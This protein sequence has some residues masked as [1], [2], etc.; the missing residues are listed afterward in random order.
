MARILDSIDSPDKLKLL[1]DEE[2][3]ILASEIRQEILRVTSKNG[4]HLASNLGTVEITL[5][6]HSLIDSPHDR[7]LFDVGHQ[8]YTH[9]LVTG[10][11]AEFDTL[12]Q[13]KGL[14][15]FPKPH[16]SA[17]D[18][19]PSGHASD[20]LS[21]AC[22]LARARDLRGE[23]QNIVALIGDAS[24][25]GG[26]AFEAL[27]DIGQAQTPLVIILNDNEMSISRNVGAMAMHLG[28]LRVTNNYRKGRD[29]MQDFMENSLGVAGKAMVKFGKT[30]KESLKQFVLPDTML[31]EQLGIVCTPPVDGHNIT[32]L[33]R[34]IGHALE[35]EVPVLVHVVTKKGAG[36]EPA[37]K[38]PASFHGVGPFDIETGKSLKPAPKALSYTQVFSKAFCAE[39][40]LDNRICAISAAMVDGTGLRQFATE[41]PERCFDVGIAEEHAVGMASGLALGGL[42]PVVAM[43][44]TF[45][46]RSIDQTIIN[47]SLENLDVVFC[48]DRA[49]LLGED[50]PTHH[51]MFDMAILRTIPNMKIIAPSNEAELVHALHTALRIG[52]PVAIRYPRGEGC[53]VPMPDDALLMKPGTCR[54]VREGSDACILAFGR[55]VSYANEAAQNL[56]DLG[57][58][59]RVVD[60]RWVKPLDVEAIRAA[61]QTGAVVTVE[62][63]VIN[64]GAGEGVA[65]VLATEGLSP[66][67][68]TLGLPDKFV[69]QGKVSQLLADCGLDVASIEKA[70]LQVMGKE[71]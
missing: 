23:K 29:S 57:Y 16:S 66:N 43:Y 42:K 41:H 11:L 35:S 8:S 49:G 4:G 56:A 15:G 58:S 24:L 37:E 48:L 14:S 55:M 13:Y 22:G 17:H 60:M 63:G 10:R 59:V 61:A 18:V 28:A 50:G 46:Q 54:V 26:M 25:A 68:R 67:L 47:V 65:E 40:A 62:D 34:T 51:G 12:R 64:G 1:N 31:F 20:S 19:H 21:V 38:D 32:A 27:N 3:S 69:T 39:A 53:G 7:F 5:A 30:A 45:L 33:R 71:Q 9:M 44:S 2:L 36:Y 70:V 6:V 52:G